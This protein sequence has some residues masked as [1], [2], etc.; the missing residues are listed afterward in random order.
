MKNKLLVSSALVSGMI[1]SG[2]AIAQTTITGSLNLDFRAVGKTT[3]ANS[4]QGFG[5][6]AQINVQNKGKLNNGFDYAAGFAIEFDGTY[7]DATTDNSSATSIS[8]ENFYFDFIYGNTTLS[9]GVDHMPNASNN[10]AP[11]ASYNQADN[12]AGLSSTITGRSGGAAKY[13]NTGGANPKEAM[14]VGIIQN[15]PGIVTLSAL[16]VPNNADTGSADTRFSQVKDGRESAFELGV[17][18]GFGVPGLTARIFYNK[19]DNNSTA[20]VRDASGREGKIYGAAYNMGQFAVGVDRFVAK[21]TTAL[22]TV[23]NNYGI[24]YAVDKN[25]SASV[26]RIKT[27]T[28]NTVQ[29]ETIWQYGIGY[30]L[31]PV[32][33]SADYTKV[34]NLSYSLTENAKMFGLHLSTKF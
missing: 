12:V 9:I 28:E 21:G 17:S 24:S 5:R 23:S 4:A 32:A 8:N 31:G 19:E 11:T 18:G 13:T 6:E 34:S 33:V 15:F 10:L 2:S 30:N 1:L 26:N 16:F 14:G 22:E 20:G 29:D 7:G 27:N 3:T 25:L